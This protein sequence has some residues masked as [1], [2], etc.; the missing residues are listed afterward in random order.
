MMDDSAIK[1]V[2]YCFANSFDEKN[3]QRLQATLADIVECDYRDLRGTYHKYTKEQFVELRIQTLQKWKTQH[4]FSNLEIAL[5]AEQAHC[6]LSALI[7][8][9]QMAK[10]QLE[11]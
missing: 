6:R 1:N 10:V 11:L 7:L 9:W 2:I 3:W 5:T 4:L 8:S